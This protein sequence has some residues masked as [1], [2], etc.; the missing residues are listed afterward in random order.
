MIPI[1]I[2]KVTEQADENNM[3]DR[4]KKI[5]QEAYKRGH[6]EGYNRSTIFI[7]VGK[8]SILVSMI[9]GIA[10]ILGIIKI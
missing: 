9:L 6:D 2:T 10:A 4:E 8:I 7:I 1:V 3:S 5:Y